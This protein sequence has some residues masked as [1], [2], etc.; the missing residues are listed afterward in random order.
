M[1]YSE[2]I[3]INIYRMFQELFN[4]AI[5]Y[6]DCKEINI[7][8]FVIENK[9]CLMVSDDGKGFDIHKSQTGFGIKNINSRVELLHGT[10]S[11]DSSTQSGTTT[12]I[13]VPLDEKV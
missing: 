11:F 12:I 7:E 8:L 10:V 2:A 1:R 3:E 13:K 5:K 9:I 4:N 6:A